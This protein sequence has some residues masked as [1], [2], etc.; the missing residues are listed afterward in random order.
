MGVA[1]QIAFEAS[2][3]ICD[4]RHCISL[5]GSF[6]CQLCN[7]AS[8]VQLG[9]TLF[10]I[11]AAALIVTSF[12]ARMRQPQPTQAPHPPASTAQDRSIRHDDKHSGSRPSTSQIIRLSSQLSP[13]K[14]GQCSRK[15]LPRL[16]ATARATEGSDDHPLQSR[17]SVPITLPRA[18]GILISSRVLIHFPPDLL[19][20]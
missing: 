1:A 17:N 3:R 13:P 19:R 10:A 4:L 16:E 11:S 2:T 6:I 7:S 14:I 12:I 9:R 15:S 5:C 8:S 18:Q 20:H